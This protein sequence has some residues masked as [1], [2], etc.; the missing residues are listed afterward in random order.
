MHPLPFSPVLHE[1]SLLEDLQMKRNL[2][3]RHINGGYNVTYTQFA[4]FKKLN[5]PQPRFIG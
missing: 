4:I 5:N 3:L 2:G 1:S